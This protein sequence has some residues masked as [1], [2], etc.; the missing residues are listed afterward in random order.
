M[1][2]KQK[3]KSPFVVIASISCVLLIAILGSV[4]YKY[5]AAQPTTN[6][7][8]PIDAQAPIE[9]SDPNPDP[10]ASTS[11]STEVAP[12]NGLDAKVEPTEQPSKKPEPNEEATWLCQHCYA[13]HRQ[14]RYAHQ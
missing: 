8:E 6:E 13:N 10:V 9:N 2:S 11:E 3:K 12:S 5:N 1:N 14:L 7:E 4:Y